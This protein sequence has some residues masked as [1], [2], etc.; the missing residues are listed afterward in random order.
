M[1]AVDESLPTLFDVVGIGAQTDVL[2]ASR[3]ALGVGGPARFVATPET[4]EAAFRLWSVLNERCVPALV[5]AEGT[6]T[7]VS[8]YGFDGVV[9]DLS[10]TFS[11][12]EYSILNRWQVGA[13][14]PIRKLLRRAVARRA[15]LSVLAQGR[16][17]VGG[18]LCAGVQCPSLVR[19]L[20][21]DG[22]G[23]RWL[24]PAEWR[25]AVSQGAWLLM[26]EIEP[27]SADEAIHATQAE[28]LTRDVR[29]A[30]GPVF[31][32]SPAESAAALLMRAGLL[33]ERVGGMVLSAAQPNYITNEGGGTAI[34]AHEL[35]SWAQREIKNRC[36]VDVSPKVHWVGAFAREGL[37]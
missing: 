15:D 20:V 12:I 30:L 24:G 13:A 33:G 5:L 26:V 10:L 36:D 18:A 2:L 28:L 11:S 8:E 7:L 21:V 37:A 25:A 9:V 34:D 27:L 32:D 23:P 17:S 14:C 19:A 3:L 22:S 16:G 29:P 31:S 35:V 4:S 6:R 1:Q